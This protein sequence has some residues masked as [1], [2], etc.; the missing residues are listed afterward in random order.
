MRICSAR[1][2]ARMIASELAL[3]RV[4]PADEVIANAKRAE[5]DLGDRS[6]RADGDRHRATA[7]HRE[8]GA[9]VV[10]A[11]SSSRDD[12]GANPRQAQAPNAPTGFDDEESA[13]PNPASEPA[14][15]HKRPPRSG[16]EG[17]HRTCRDPDRAARSRMLRVD[18]PQTLI[19]APP[20]P[21][22]AAA[23]RHQ[24]P[25][26]GPADHVNRAGPFSRDAQRR[27]PH[28]LGVNEDDLTEVP[29]SE[30][31]RRAVRRDDATAHRIAKP[32]R[33]ADG[34][35]RLSVNPSQARR[36]EL[37]RVHVRR[38]LEDA[39]IG[40]MVGAADRAAAQESD[41]EQ[42]QSFA[43]GQSCCLTRGSPAISLTCSTRLPRRNRSPAVASTSAGTSFAHDVKIWGAATL[44]WVR[45][46]FICSS[47]SRWQSFATSSSSLSRAASAP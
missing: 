15:E 33:S 3:R 20:L 40:R 45:T 17:R 7:V 13:W 8:A 14:D 10:G 37:V 19:E 41:D 39:R 36:L 2:F 26:A 24:C 32:E 27:A 30:G 23:R 31:D 47:V 12:A 38:E 9:D 42:R 5:V 6:S 1:P 34:Q 44:I 25:P 11:E 18:Q 29:T 4:E 21:G 16:V 35:Q 22:V 46:H 28:C 43:H